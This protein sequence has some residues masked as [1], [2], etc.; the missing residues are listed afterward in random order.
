MASEK[1]LSAAPVYRL[2]S[3]FSIPFQTGFKG[4]Y[5]PYVADADHIPLRERAFFAVDP[6]RCVDYASQSPEAKFSELIESFEKA[7]LI[8]SEVKDGAP[9]LTEL[10]IDECAGLAQFSRDYAGLPSAECTLFRD[11]N[12]CSCLK[13][14]EGLQKTSVLEYKRG[15]HEPRLHL[16]CAISRVIRFS[17]GLC[18]KG[19][20]IAWSGFDIRWFRR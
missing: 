2:R 11:F 12:R 10:S 6:H 7:A 3:S 16:V 18:F 5:P 19:K 4:A 1:C 15:H 13:D 14:D 8:V 20:A 17:V 9:F